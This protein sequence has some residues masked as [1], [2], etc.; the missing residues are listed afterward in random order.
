LRD[1]KSGHRW[2]TDVLLEKKLYKY[3]DSIQAA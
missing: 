1:R 3:F 2:K